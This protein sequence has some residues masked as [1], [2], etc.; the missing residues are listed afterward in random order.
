MAPR[1]AAKA[2]D[3]R[4]IEAMTVV[5]AELAAEQ[6]ARAREHRRERRLMVAVAVVV[7]LFGA[8]MLGLLLEARFARSTF[9]EGF[10]QSK[11]D[12]IEVNVVTIQCLAG[13]N[14]DEAAFERCVRERLA[15]P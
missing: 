2:A 6:K 4:V 5:R 14:G 3:E 8:L 12:G 15:Q 1:E 11:Q 13:A 7:L 9:R 10:E